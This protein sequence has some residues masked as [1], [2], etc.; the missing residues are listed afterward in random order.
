MTQLMTEQGMVR[1]PAG[2]WAVDPAHS[3]VAFQVKHMMTPTV[4]GQFREYRVT[5][6]LTIK[7]GVLVGQAVKIL[8]DVSAVRA[9]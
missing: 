1:V 2:T 3:S 8:I 4:R 7:G 5:G 9:S 6:D